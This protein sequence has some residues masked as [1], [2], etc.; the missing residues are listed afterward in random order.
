MLS[1]YSTDPGCSPL[2]LLLASVLFLMA[3]LVPHHKIT[4]HLEA[5]KELAEF[6]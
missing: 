3:I 1:D 5:G 2:K 4:Q 6:C